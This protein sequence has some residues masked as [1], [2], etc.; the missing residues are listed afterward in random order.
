MS[1]EGRLF[2]VS[3]GAAGPAWGLLAA[4]VLDPGSFT[5]ES[6]GGEVLT[7]LV[8]LDIAALFALT[9][10]RSRAV[11]GVVGALLTIFALVVG[12]GSGLV[13][14]VA[15]APRVA[16]V[17]VV[18][19]AAATGAGFVASVWLLVEKIVARTGDSEASDET[20]LP[21]GQVQQTTVAGNRVGGDQRV[22]PR[23]HQ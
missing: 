4:L 17:L 16:N 13:A 10:F 5:P 7:T 18:P 12:L 14:L 22:E 8:G 23:Q 20:K 21:A 11:P 3:L 15:N 19:L 6:S 1:G 9:I 2:W